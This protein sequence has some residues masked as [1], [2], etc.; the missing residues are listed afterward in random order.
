M[1]IGAPRNP[2]LDRFRFFVVINARAPPRLFTW[3]NPIR[4]RAA[5]HNRIPQ[6]K[7]DWDA[8]RLR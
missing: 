5:I 6:R 8:G 7:A 4:A 1:L 3:E 2:D